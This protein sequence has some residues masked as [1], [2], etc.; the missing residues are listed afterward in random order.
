[1]TLALAVA[2]VLG[3]LAGA[4][5]RSRPTALPGLLCGGILLLVESAPV[6]CRIVSGSGRMGSMPKKY[7]AEERDRA[8][9]MVREQVPEFGSVTAAA[10]A[11]ATRLGMSRET[12]RNWCKQS[13]ID[14]GQAVGV[15]S[16]ERT[17]IK[18]LKAKV[19]RL[20]EDNVILKAAA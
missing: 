11:V 4:L 20:E 10:G 17:E 2:L 13:E 19:R 12:I 8:V 3:A 18:E 5:V 14:A 16:D 1:M 9:R 6:S 15:T 7:T